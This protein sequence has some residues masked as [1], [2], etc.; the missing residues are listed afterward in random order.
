[1]KYAY[2]QPEAEYPHEQVLEI[3]ASDDDY[4]TLSETF[5]EELEIW[6]RRALGANGFADY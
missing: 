4:L 6:A 2:Q 3:E 1:M 5:N